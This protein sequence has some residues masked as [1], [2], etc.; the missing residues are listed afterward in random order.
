MRKTHHLC[1]SGGKELLFRTQSDYIHGIVCLSLA[2]SKSDTEILAYCLMSNHIHLCVRTYDVKRFITT[3]RYPY[4]C[5]FN[6]RYERRGRLGERHFF[7]SEIKG[8]HHLLTAIAYILR[9]PMHHGIC[10]TPFE[11]TYSSIRAA[12][13]KELGYTMN[14]NGRDLKA[15][16]HRMPDR[17]HLPHKTIMLKDGLVLPESIIDTPDVEHLFGTA[18]TYLYYMNRISGEVW[19]NEQQKDGKDITPVRIDDIERGVM[20]EPIPRL[21]ANEFGRRHPQAVSDIELCSI[22]DEHIAKVHSIKSI[23]SLQPSDI[24]NIKSFLKDKYHLTNDQIHRCLA[25]NNR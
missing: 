24:L 2:A 21:L 7:T 22:I 6:S 19:E 17:N 23:Y 18:R 20:C 4:S 8:I 13:Q 16:Y 10:A 14:L 15:R 5:Y 11:Y 9:N 3:F 25:T 1:W 12:F